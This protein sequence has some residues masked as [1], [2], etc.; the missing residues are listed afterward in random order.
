MDQE[1]SARSI[2][3]VWRTLPVNLDAETFMI[4]PREVFSRS[5]SPG[6]PALSNSERWMCNQKKP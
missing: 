6:I 4:S 1:D 3:V 5:I 2:R